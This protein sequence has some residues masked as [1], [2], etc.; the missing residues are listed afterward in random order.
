MRIASEG[1]AGNSSAGSAQH[2]WEEIPERT[3]YLERVASLGAI[4]FLCR[5]CSLGGYRRVD[6]NRSP[7]KRLANACA[8][9]SLVKQN[10]TNS[11]SSRRKEYGRGTQR[12]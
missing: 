10:T 6:G 4:T 9:S 2:P 1:G 3:D 12:V 5:Q 7:S 11:P 8:S